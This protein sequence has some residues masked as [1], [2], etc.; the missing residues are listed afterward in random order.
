MAL[1]GAFIAVEK[2]LPWKRLANRSVSA[3]LVLIAVG[4]ALVP[5]AAPG[6]PM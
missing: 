5:G 6:M 2:M 1:V 4:I 3:A